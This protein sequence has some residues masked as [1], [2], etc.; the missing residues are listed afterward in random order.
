VARSHFCQASA[1][2]TLPPHPLTNL[3]SA[4]RLAIPVASRLLGLCA[5]SAAVAACVELTPL[6][7][8]VTE[9][10]AAALPSLAWSAPFA[11]RLI[12]ARATFSALML[13]YASV[14][15]AKPAAR[16]MSML[17]DKMRQDRYLVGFQLQNKEPG[18]GASGC[19]EHVAA[20]ADAHDKTD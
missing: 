15:C 2:P 9:Q 3:L 10:G 6:R 14:R 11:L 5:V 12:C 18:I 19:R 20:A 7:L 16:W 1:D 8:L 13:W 17:H 4:S